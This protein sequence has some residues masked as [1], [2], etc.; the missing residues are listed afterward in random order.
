MEKNG[1][2]KKALLYV[3]TAVVLGAAV[4]I[5]PQWIF[6]IS[7]AGTG[8]AN[9]DAGLFGRALSTSPKE[10][11]FADVPESPSYE[12]TASFRE[13][14]IFLVALVLALGVRFF[15]KRRVPYPSYR[16]R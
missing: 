10:W 4:M 15:Y 5:F 9:E 12:Q 6:W 16:A 7:Y 8:I 14:E 13:V 2:M 1:T 11:Q 3:L